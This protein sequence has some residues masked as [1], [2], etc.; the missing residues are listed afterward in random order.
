MG[1]GGKFSLAPTLQS[2]QIQ[3]GGLVRKYALVHQLYACHSREHS[4]NKLGEA[5]SR[6][7]II[8]ANGDESVR[9]VF[10]IFLCNIKVRLNA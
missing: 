6:Q 3:D 9:I 4:L 5:F 10:E 8:A 7:L 2:Y 1:W